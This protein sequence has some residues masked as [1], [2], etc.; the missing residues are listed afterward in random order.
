[1][2]SRSQFARNTEV[3]VERS[4]AEIEKLLDRYGATSFGYMR[5]EGTAIVLFQVHERR[6]KFTVEMPP[7]NS[8]TRTPTGKLRTAEQTMIEWEKACRRHWRVLVLVVKAKL[9]AVET[10]VVSFEEEFLAHIVLP[11]GRT[12]GEWAGTQLDQIYL[13]GQ[14][15][16]FLPGLPSGERAEA[17]E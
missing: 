1:V 7:V 6:V 12:V 13:S 11:D 16:P 3:S 14:M 9:E 15:P 8:F 5:D 17:S 10:G 2:S 4:K